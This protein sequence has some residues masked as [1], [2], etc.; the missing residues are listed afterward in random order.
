MVLVRINGNNTVITKR[1]DGLVDFV[2]IRA[3]SHTKS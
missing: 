3:L 2:A 1:T